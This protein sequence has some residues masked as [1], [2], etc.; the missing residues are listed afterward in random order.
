MTME[1][2]AKIHVT[3]AKHAPHTIQKVEGR[4]IDRKMKDPVLL[5]AFQLLERDKN[6]A[7]FFQLYQYAVQGKLEGY[8][9]FSQICQVLAD[10]VRRDTSGDPNAK[11]GIR[12]PANYLNFMILLRSYGAKS[13]RQYGILTGQIPGPSPRHLRCV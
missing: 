5:K 9:T 4:D 13:A 3:R 12:Y 7:G 6:S 1:E 2:Q 8:D 11:Y 10:R